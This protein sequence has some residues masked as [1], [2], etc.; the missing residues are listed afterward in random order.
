MKVEHMLTRDAQD[1]CLLI[2]QVDG[3]VE[4]QVAG[5]GDGDYEMRL[6]AIGSLADES[7]A[8]H[9]QLGISQPSN[10]SFWGTAL[11]WAEPLTIAHLVMDCLNNQ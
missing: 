8:L 11:T 7:H 4:I 2:I 3:R 9:T 6:R 10:A 1:N 5:Y